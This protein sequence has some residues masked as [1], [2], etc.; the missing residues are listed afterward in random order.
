MRPAAKCSGSVH[1]PLRKSTLSVTQVGQ[2]FSMGCGFRNMRP[3]KQPMVR[4][5]P[6]S[7]GLVSVFLRAVAVSGRCDRNEADSA[8]PALGRCGWRWRDQ[9]APLSPLGPL[10]GPSPRKAGRSDTATLHPHPPHA[11]RPPPVRAPAPRRP[12]SRAA[13]RDRNHTRGLR[14]H[15]HRIRR[16]P[17]RPLRRRALCPRRGQPRAGSRWWPKWNTSA[18]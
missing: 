10:C 3:K 9:A 12:R 17:G 13:Q 4:G 5:L 11:R 8:E 15:D 14:R 7:D 16:R 6:L 1:R 18:G 2:E